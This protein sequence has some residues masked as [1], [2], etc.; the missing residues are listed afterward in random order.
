MVARS[1]PLNLWDLRVDNCT[2]RLFG[3]VGQACSAGRHG[4]SLE[5]I[6]GGAPPSARSR[7]RV[8]PT[9]PP[10]CV[11]PPVV[12]P[13]R[14]ALANHR[15]PSTLLSA[16]RCGTHARRACGSHHRRVRARRA[17]ASLTCTGLRCGGL[18]HPRGRDTFSGVPPAATRPAPLPASPHFR[19]TCPTL[20]RH[21]DP[22]QLLALPPL[23]Y[24]R[25]TAPNAIFCPTLRC[26]SS[27]G[28]YL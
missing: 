21:D 20:V 15:G 7:G 6:W 5:A 25:C 17:C 11:P 28:R 2:A 26:S 16:G 3:H 18:Y 4:P 13:L 1:A 27:R 24:R 14:Q 8:S 23:L 22:L 19:T 10:H 9:R 12:W